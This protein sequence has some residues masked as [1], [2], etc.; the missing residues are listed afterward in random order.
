[1][2]RE[3]RSAVVRYRRLSSSCRDSSLVDLSGRAHDGQVEP[4]PAAKAPRRKSGSGGLPNGSRVDRPPGT[5]R[6]WR[7]SRTRSDWVGLLTLLSVLSRK[8][9]SKGKVPGLSGDL[10]D[11]SGSAFLS[12]A[13]DAAAAIPAKTAEKPQHSKRIPQCLNAVNSAVTL[14]ALK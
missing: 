8:R 12:L 4:S 10:R 11:I 2:P 13:P 3:E 1:G 6:S 14:S 9:E 5:P 7:S